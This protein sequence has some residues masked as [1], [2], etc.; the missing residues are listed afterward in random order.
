MVK[1]RKSKH[2]PIYEVINKDEVE[3]LK[4]QGFKVVEETKKE[5]IKKI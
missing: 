5:T 2:D 4:K 1:V 3:K